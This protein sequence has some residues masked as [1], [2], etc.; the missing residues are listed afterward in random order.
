VYKQHH[1]ELIAV[2]GLSSPLTHEVYIEL[3]YDELDV[4][5]L[6]VELV[7]V[8]VVLVV[9]VVLLL[10]ELDLALELLEVVVAAL[11]A[12]M[13]SILSATDITIFLICF[14]F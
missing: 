6:E 2:H 9:V 14:I 13:M 3:S 8:F 10:D 4:V 1:V 11:M 5:S 12:E 7:V